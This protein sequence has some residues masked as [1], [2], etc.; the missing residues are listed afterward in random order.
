M[1]GVQALFWGSFAL[2]A[3][4]YAGYPILLATWSRLKAGPG[5]TDGG[6]RVETL[7]RVS[8]II[9]AYNEEQVIARKIRNSLELNYPSDLL[10]IVVISDGSNDATEPL[11]REAAGERARL[12]FLQD[13]QGK[14]ACINTVL[15]S[16]LGQVVVRKS[17]AL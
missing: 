6:H 4:T 1:D 3:Y 8:L 15:P 11:A 2:T 10:E 7:P 9:P 17:R 14:T 5:G 16:L 13:R 12:V